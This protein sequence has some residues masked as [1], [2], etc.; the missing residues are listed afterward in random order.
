MWACVRSGIRSALVGVAWLVASAAPAHAQQAIGEARIYA[1]ERIVIGGSTFG[2]TSPIQAVGLPNLAGTLATV[3]GSGNIGLAATGTATISAILSATG[4]VNLGDA[5]GDDIAVNGRLTTAL[6]WKTDNTVDIGASGANRAR[7]FFL[8]RNAAIGGT[9]GVTGDTTLTGDLAINGNDLTSSGVLTIRPTGN[10]TLD[11]TGDVIVG[12]DG[13][14]VLPA[15]GYAYNL[16][17]LTNK[18]LTLHAAELWVETLVAQNTIATIGGR[19]LVGPT[20][21]LAADLTNVATT[22]SV[23]HNSL[24]NGDR[25][26]LEANGSVEFIA[27]AS[28][29]SG[30]GPYTYTITRDLDG[31][32]A[33]AWTA[34]DA[35]FNTGQT[36]NGFIDLYS[37]RGVKAGTEVGPTI[38]G[39]VRTSSTYNAWSP[40]WAIGN[41]NGLY[42]YGA[43]TYGAAFG[44]PSATNVTV[45]AT[46]G[47]RIRRGGTTEAATWDTSGVLRMYDTGGVRRVYLDAASGLVLGDT[48]AGEM[49][50]QIDGSSMSFCLAGTSCNFNY[51][52]ATGIITIGYTGAEHVSIS[53]SI[54][55]F[56]DGAT[57]MGSLDGSTLVLGQPLTANNTGQFYVD[58][59]SIDLRWRDNVGSTSSLFSIQKEPSASGGYASLIGR[60]EVV[61]SGSGVYVDQIQNQS[62][63]TLTIK[64][65]SGTVPQVI[66]DTAA[67]GSLRPL[68]AA[69]GSLG[70]SVAQWDEFYFTPTTT[71]TDYNPLVL[72]ANGQV[73]E[74]TDGV[75]ATFNPTTCSS[76]T[77]HSGMLVAKV[78]C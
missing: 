11:P 7:D 41:L 78:G 53:G 36:G 44:D 75:S 25:V 59:D 37:V 55:E 18:F 40:R 43:T 27:V 3:D 23:K 19:I 52:A 1:T 29:A 10:L 74:K 31:S 69:T 57:V 17:A 35:V 64:A 46:N 14:D 50:A 13:S 42:G 47:F 5:S 56:K 51:T 76:M 4:A 20:T 63:S 60:L 8:G 33:N 67:N 71:T 70:T 66:V 45:D 34:G 26:Y 15:S 73:L 6:L 49:Y 39:N 22:M 48:A 16:G 9:L 58:S 68:T 12:A 32:G 62:G 77:F 30:T 54:L 2:S 72:G 65:V 21:Q 38:V 24:A 61:K 28:A